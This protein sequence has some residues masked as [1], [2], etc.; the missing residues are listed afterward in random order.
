M[1]E[2]DILAALTP[3][4]VSIDTLTA[5]VETYK[6]LQGATS[7]V[8]SLR[9]EVA[10]LRKDVDYLKSTDFTSLFELTED[11]N[12]LT[13][14]KMPPATTRDVPIDNIATDE[15]EAETDE[16]HLGERDPVI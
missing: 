13:I 6:S 7:E 1:V 16:E 12:A 11:R 5:R 2:R 3:L 10:N 14:S 4:R 8:T 15:S 9:A